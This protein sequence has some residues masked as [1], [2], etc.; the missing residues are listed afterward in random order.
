MS[1]DNWMENIWDCIK[2]K[3]IWRVALPGTHNSGVFSAWNTI[4][5]R[6]QDKD[7]GEQ[8]TGGIRSF[9]IRVTNGHDT[10]VMHHSGAYPPN[11]SQNLK[12]ALEQMRSFAVK[13]PYEIFVVRLSPGH[14]SSLKE[15]EW[16]CLR[17]MILNELENHLVPWDSSNSYTLADIKNSGKNIILLSGV[18]KQAGKESLFW[19]NNQNFLKDTWEGYQSDF[20]PTPTE[21]INWLKLHI[22]DALR[23]PPRRFLYSS[24]MIWTINLYDAAKQWT[25]PQVCSWISQ[26]AIDPDLKDGMN[27]FA[28]DFFDVWDNQVVNTII[29]INKALPEENIAINSKQ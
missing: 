25:N 2:E 3:E 14:G 9:D 12:P 6:N 26:W 16:P 4:G 1:N 23:H 17:E 5:V 28:F 24:C 7:I 15:S 13:H 29:A 20:F 22:E 10:F 18:G 11:D 21:K 8:L 27:I 19:D